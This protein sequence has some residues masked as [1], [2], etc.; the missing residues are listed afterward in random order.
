MKA[1]LAR[2]VEYTEIFDDSPRPVAEY[3]SGLSR[4]MRLTTAVYLLGF[5]GFKPYQEILPRL[6][7]AHNQAYANSIVSRLRAIE[8]FDGAMVALVGDVAKLRFF[9]LI[10]QLPDEAQTQSEVEMERSI[11]KAL[12]VL[13]AELEEQYK[14]A[15]AAAPALPGVEEMVGLLLLHSHTSYD[16]SQDQMEQL[17]IAQMYKCARL[18][19]FLATDVAYQPLLQAFL[20]YF[21]CSTWQE[22]AFRLFKL[23]GAVVEMLAKPGYM[24]LV[25]DPGEGYDRDCAFL[26]RF[27]LAEGT[28]LIQQDFL[29]TREFPL[30]KSAP[31]HYVIV[32]PRFVLELLHKGLY[33][34]LKKLNEHP[35]PAPAL[36]GKKEWGSVYKKLFSEELLLIPAL[37]A[38]LGK[39]GLALSGKVIEESGVLRKLGNGEPDYYFRAHKRVLLIESKDVNVR[40]EVKTGENYAEFIEA[41]RSKFYRPTGAPRTDKLSGTGILQLVGNIKR[42]LNYGLPFDTKYTAKNLVFYPILVVHDRSFNLPGLNA[43]VNSWFQSE[44]AYQ[45][46]HGM[47]GGSIKPL[48]IIDIDTMLAYQDRFANGNNRLVLWDAIDAYYQY[49]RADLFAQRPR[50]Q[51]TPAEFKE[52][53]LTEA[54][55]HALSF[56][57]FLGIYAGRMGM[58]PFSETQKVYVRKLLASKEYANS[59]A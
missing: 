48:V 58:A 29:S 15:S 31:G 42:L 26:D 54:Y 27:T 45:R 49:T 40:K 6:F 51:Y 43:L 25:L 21:A 28:T 23:V 33:F 46:Q 2:V 18:F 57:D 7:G 3:L 47:V 53:A 14:I 9:E 38:A 44:V 56:S 35:A 12:M 8:R 5:R 22:Y 41:M 10:F 34:R 52:R 39:R 13:N 55:R 1:T 4:E 32:Y 16:V 19:E 11:F 17:V 30:Y 37:D 59:P 36:L 50:R 24:T 20:S